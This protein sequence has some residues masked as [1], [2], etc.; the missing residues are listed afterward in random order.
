M[1]EYGDLIKHCTQV[2]GS[3]ESKKKKLTPDFHVD[4]YFEEQQVFTT[5][6]YCW[7]YTLIHLHT[8]IADDNARLFVEQVFYGCLQYKKMLRVLSIHCLHLILS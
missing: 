3:F 6:L 4:K 8:Q 5:H 7:Y 2:L 1:L